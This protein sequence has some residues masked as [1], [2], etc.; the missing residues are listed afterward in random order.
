MKLLNRVFIRHW[1]QVDC[2]VIPFAQLNFLTGK[3]ASGKST[4]VDALQF[5]FLGDKHGHYFNKAANDKSSR[6]L[7][8][9]LFCQDGFNDERDQFVFQRDGKSFNTYLLAEF[10]SEKT[11][12]FFTIGAVFDCYPDRSFT[13]NYITYEGSIPENEFVLNGQVMNVDM[14]KHFFQSNLAKDEWEMTESVERYKENMM[15]FF[16]PIKR[17]FFHLLKKAVPFSPIMN[18]KQFI[19]EFVSDVP[20][21]VEVDHLRDNIRSYKLLQRDLLNIKEQVNELEIIEAQYNSYLEL[22]R[23]NIIEKYIIDRAEWEIK[24]EEIYRAILSRED[25]QKACILEKEHKNQLSDSLKAVSAKIIQLVQDNGNVEAAW[26]R[27][28]A[29]YNQANIL[30]KES[31]NAN[32]N[33]KNMFGNDLAVWKVLINDV[34]SYAIQVSSMKELGSCILSVDELYHKSPYA[35]TYEDLDLLRRAMN[36]FLAELR[37]LYYNTSLE[38]NSLNAEKMEKERLLSSLQSG[39]S[40]YPDPKI[41]LLKDSIAQYLKHKYEKDI[42][43]HVFCELLDIKDKTWQNAI[44]GYL[45]TQ[46]FHLIVPP[47]YFRDALMVYEREK[48]IKEIYNVG[49][50]DIGRILHEKPNA[51]EGSLAEEVSTEN[52]YAEA[53]VNYLLGHVMKA[54]HTD[55]FQKHT[56][57]ITSSCMLYQGYVARQIHPKTYKTPYIGQQSLITRKEQCKERISE[58]SLNIKDVKNREAQYKKWTSRDSWNE[59]T[60]SLLFGTDVEL[61]FIKKASMLQQRILAWEQARKQ[62]KEYDQSDLIAYQ[63]SKAEL[64]KESEK[65]RGLI[66]NS[67]NRIRHLESKETNLI[68]SIDKLQEEEAVLRKELYERYENDWREQYGDPRYQDALEN[69]RVHKKITEFF[70]NKSQETEG[71]REQVYSLIV[72]LRS[73]YGKRNKGCT[74][75]YFEKTNDSWSLELKELK[76]TALQS[77]E[78]KIEDAKDRAQ[79]QFQEDFISKLKS[80]IETIQEQIIDLNSAI[81]NVPLDIA[82]TDLLL[83]QIPGIY[84]III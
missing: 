39:I 38:L 51:R 37:T 33:V 71:H 64:D 77:Y 9:Y 36:T 54:Y 79:E 43:V 76:E 8:G 61:G 41:K 65:L 40:E 46:K 13:M 74:L 49:L 83:R 22:A 10:K 67:S 59:N 55:D 6:S 2:A 48:E 24:K 19:T 57:A 53:Y 72:R 30:M 52:E 68:N 17:N 80:N 84:N 35:L 31:E 21:T 12:S 16:G 29:S 66:D 28:N 63:T 58:I 73:E 23:E 1:H 34:S 78:E 26:D 11:N 5:I 15:K 14:L 32:K 20:E 4:I 69:H 27:L 70:Y 42:D 47:E 81:Q 44:E 7:E 82:D 56:R 18:I 50:V 75:N 3:N 45:N 62:L 60:L 25:T